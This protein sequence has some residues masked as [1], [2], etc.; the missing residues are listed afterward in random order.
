MHS[1]EAKFSK[2]AQAIDKGVLES[3]K[4]VSIAGG[5]YKFSVPVPIDVFLNEKENS[6]FLECDH[7]AADLYK[8]KYEQNLT[9]EEIQHKLDLRNRFTKFTMVLHDLKIPFQLSAGTLLGWYRQCDVIP[10]TNDVDVEMKQSDFSM[11][12]IRNLILAG[13]TLVHKE[14]KLEDSLL[15]QFYLFKPEIGIDLFIRY[16]LRDYYWFGGTVE[17]LNKYM[18]VFDKYS[19]CWTEFLNLKVKVPCDPL[20]YIITIYGEGWKKPVKEYSYMSSPNNIMPAGSWDTSLRN[21]VY[22][23]FE[24]IQLS[25]PVELKAFLDYIQYIL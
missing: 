16:E 11:E 25:D 12:I 7:T 5:K 20:L 9:A 10:Y 21:E 15:F 24:P 18:N 2:Y 4:T 19:L 22:A 13:F 14:G 3:R 1:F 8:Q 6:Q 17:N 23:W